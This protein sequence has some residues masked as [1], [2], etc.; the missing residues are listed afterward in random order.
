M[1]WLLTQTR[2]QITAIIFDSIWP[3]SCNF[4]CSGVV[5]SSAAN[6]RKCHQ[7]KENAKKRRKRVEKSAKK[8]R[9]NA[10]Q[11]SAKSQEKSDIFTIVKAGLNAADGGGCAGQD[12]NADGVAASHCFAPYSCSCMAP[13]EPVLPKVEEKDM[14]TLS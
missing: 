14:L 6:C 5:S 2:M 13:Q 12:D 9:K 11:K 4:A 8:R 1:F 7:N 10:S 3:N